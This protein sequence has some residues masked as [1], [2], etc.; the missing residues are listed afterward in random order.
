MVGWIADGGTSS[1][2]TIPKGYIPYIGNTNRTIIQLVTPYS[3]YSPPNYD[4]HIRI[5]IDNYEIFNDEVSWNNF[6]VFTYGGGDRGKF[7]RHTFVNQEDIDHERPPGFTRD[8]VP[9]DVL[10]YDNLKKYISDESVIDTS[11]IRFSV[12]RTDNSDS[13]GI[14]SDSS[15]S[16]DSFIDDISANNKDLT[17]YNRYLVNVYEENDVVPSYSD[18]SYVPWNTRYHTITNTRDPTFGN[19][20]GT[21][22]STA[23]INYMDAKFCWILVFDNI[24]YGE[25]IEQHANGGWGITETPCTVFNNSTIHGNL[26]FDKLN[27]L[28]EL[29]LQ[30]STI[31]GNLNLPKLEVIGN[32]D[33]KLQ[34]VSINGNLNLSGLISIENIN[35][36]SNVYVGGDI[37]LSDLSYIAYHDGDVGLFSDKFK[38]DGNINLSNLETVSSK[39]TFYKSIIGAMNNNRTDIC[40]NLSSLLSIEDPSSST[41]NDISPGL[42]EEATINMPI[43]F[44]NNLL[45]FKNRQFYN[46]SINTRLAV[47]NF[48]Y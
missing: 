16:I 2:I 20:S 8:T 28:S 35:D 12:Y 6:S 19:I 32:G 11:T 43:I 33:N 34:D 47:S 48:Y 1:K 3:E 22:M 41:I 26:N 23:N 36:I 10:S 42:F 27:R 46:A 17:T 38:I 15:Y 18:L 5:W 4:V 13:S 9:L 24:P 30:N 29:A 39:G 21:N 37:D 40:M 44:G 14:I 45:Y 31:Y 25:Q 7:G